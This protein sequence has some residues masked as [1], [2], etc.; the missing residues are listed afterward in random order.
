M[1]QYPCLCS[2]W[3]V[4]LNPKRTQITIFKH[5]NSQKATKL[6]QKVNVN[7]LG[8]KLAKQTEVDYLR[9]SLSHALNWS[10]DVQCTLDK[11]QRQA[12]LLGVLC[13]LFGQCNPYTLIHTC[14]SFMSPVAEYRAVPDGVLSPHLA[15]KL[16]T[17]KRC[18]L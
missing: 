15:Y 6:H 9:I 3:K 7:L 17:L 14:N 2:R 11:M 16:S 13:G 4:S 1:S 12:S 10:L 8:V 18:I 5:P